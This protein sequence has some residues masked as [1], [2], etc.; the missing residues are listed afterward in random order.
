MSFNEIGEFITEIGEEVAL[1]PD[2]SSEQ[3]AAI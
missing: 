3:C 1:F 2:F